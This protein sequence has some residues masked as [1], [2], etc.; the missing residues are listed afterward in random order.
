MNLQ[1]TAISVL[2]VC[3]SQGDNRKQFPCAHPSLDYTN[4]PRELIHVL[5]PSTA[6]RTVKAVKPVFAGCTRPAVFR[7][8][9]VAG[10]LR[11]AQNKR[12]PEGP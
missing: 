7:D 4:L 2:T 8:A 6:T 11:D 9:T 1:R 12:F 3:L 10:K 5:K